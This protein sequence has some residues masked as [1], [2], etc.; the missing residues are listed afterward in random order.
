[1]SFHAMCSPDYTR[2]WKRSGLFALA[3]CSMSLCSNIAKSDDAFGAKLKAGQA[4]KICIGCFPPAEALRAD[5]RWMNT[6]FDLDLHIWR[7][8][9]TGGLAR[10]HLY[11]GYANDRLGHSDADGTYFG[12]WRC[13]DRGRSHDRGCP[14][15]GE[16]FNVPSKAYDLAAN[17][18]LTYCFAVQLWKP[19]TGSETW[20][21]VLT[22]QGVA[23]LRC[24]GG[25]FASMNDRTAQTLDPFQGKFGACRDAYQQQKTARAAVAS[26]KWSGMLALA[27]PAADKPITASDVKWTPD[28]TC[29]MIGISDR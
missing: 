27:L 4:V 1:M 16:K 19:E 18:A 21:L 28:L 5:L 15:S 3:L 12:T 14:S 20:E 29:Q 9:G 10:E 2:V 25:Q 26:K 11:F 13:D 23:Q 6:A 24:S 8:S 17:E 22:H 7:P